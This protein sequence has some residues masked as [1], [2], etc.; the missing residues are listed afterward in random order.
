MAVVGLSSV[1]YDGVF[2]PAIRGMPPPHLSVT[3]YT[4]GRV[5]LRSLVSKLRGA[6][7]SG[8]VG[9][10]RL[11]DTG[12]IQ[13]TAGEELLL[14]TDQNRDRGIC[15]MRRN[16]QGNPR[17]FFMVRVAVMAIGPIL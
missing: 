5:W 16:H 8:A 3:L 11:L 4:D 10:A 1:L 9:A 7:D 6:V 2:A 12:P 14:R 17:S 15:K 13:G